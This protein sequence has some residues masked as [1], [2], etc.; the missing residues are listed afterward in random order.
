MVK[1]Y[2]TQNEGDCATCSLVNYGRDCQSNSLHGGKRE[3]S[4]RKTTGRKQRSI[5]LNEE[6]FDKVKG[7]VKSLRDE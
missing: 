2:C 6:E 4:G 1:D 7:F 5:W 3:G